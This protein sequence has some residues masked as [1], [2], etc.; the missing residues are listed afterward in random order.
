M[1]QPKKRP[2]RRSDPE[3]LL[4]RT[5]AFARKSDDR[6]A[7][8]AESAREQEVSR[9]RRQPSGE[10]GTPDKRG[11]VRSNAPRKLTRTE[12]D[13]MN[14]WRRRCTAAFSAF[15]VVGCVMG[16]LLFARPA[17]SAVEN[18]E[19]TRFP[20]FTWE[21]FV[22]GSF[23]NDV[24][25]WYADTYPIREP[26]VAANRA[27]AS[28][29]GIDTGTKMI[30]GNV[31]S[32][33]LPPIDEA[34]DG[35][36]DPSAGQEELEPE[37]RKAVEVPDEAAMAEN[38]QN[39]VMGGLYVKDGAAYSFY[40]FLEDSVKAYTA[41]VN[42]CTEAVK[43]EAE[44]FSIL[45]PNNSGVLL[46]EQTLADM[47]GTDQG[48]AIEYFDSLFVP[49]VHTV[50]ILEPLR[51]HND[52]YLYFRTDHH[53]TQLGAYYAYLEFC[54]KAGIEPVPLEDHE[55]MTFDGFLGTYYS[56]LQDP[57][58]A[59]NPDYVQAYIPNGTNDM[60]YQDAAGNELEGKVIT[61]VSDWNNNSYYSTFIMGDQPLEHIVNDKKDDDSSVLVVKDSYGCAF[62]PLLVDNFHDVYVIDFRH[63]DLNIP[64]F[65]REHG[66]RNVVFL[67]NVTLAGTDGVAD[68]LMSMM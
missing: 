10:P 36:N 33:E 12:F 40:Y 11:D 44:V 32:D 67:N 16:A 46:D 34:A 29:Y 15:L 24:S 54:E 2:T 1:S 42:A 51:S 18:R 5:T 9:P 57:A 23:L 3:G 58:M 4:S 28:L 65:V 22:D 37:E 7:S 35:S 38:I 47:G 48:Q 14:R 63:I 59:A 30:G 41:A 19:L 50:D 43:G 39:A 20:A 49:E 62:V 25:L 27:V 31:K 64:D 66:I 52:E 13:A 55:S 8:H 26:L 53:W 45:V 60:T 17:A 61:D 68:K 21:G 56:E 6:V